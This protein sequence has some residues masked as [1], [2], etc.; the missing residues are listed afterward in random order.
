MYGND[1]GCLFN[2]NCNLVCIVAANVVIFIYN[3]TEKH[4]VHQSHNCQLHNWMNM[5]LSNWIHNTNII[6]CW[7]NTCRSLKL[8]LQT[9]NCSWQ[10]TTN[11][12]RSLANEWPW[13][14]GHPNA[15]S[16]R[17]LTA[18]KRLHY[19]HRLASVRVLDGCIT[20]M[21]TLLRLDN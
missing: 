7:G 20:P 2:F 15:C 9:V 19:T 16:T 1:G 3:T 8:E 5:S 10:L 17:P 4:T 12:S 21:D 6:I 13:C 18:I 11:S 14:A